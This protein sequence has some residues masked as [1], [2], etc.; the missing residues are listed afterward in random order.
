MLAI[1]VDLDLMKT[2]EE[3]K[4][5]EPVGLAE[6]GEVALEVRKGIRVLVRVLIEVAEV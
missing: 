1:L 3:V 6:R 2:L 4:G 5:G